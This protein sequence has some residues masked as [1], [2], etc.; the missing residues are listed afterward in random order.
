M[1]AMDPGSAA[2]S[3]DIMK[4]V[5]RSLGKE[6]LIANVVFENSVCSL[7][8]CD[9]QVKKYLFLI[10]VPMFIFLIFVSKMCKY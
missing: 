10:K 5:K 6:N 7:V 4:D 9:L 1:S 3:T 2:A 8:T